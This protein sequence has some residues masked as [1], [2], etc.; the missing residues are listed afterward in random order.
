MVVMIEINMSCLDSITDSMHMNLS[1]LWE[2]EDDRGAWLTAVSMGSQRVRHDLAT[3]Q[4][5]LS[6]HMC[7]D[8]NHNDDIDFHLFFQQYLYIKLNPSFLH[9]PIQV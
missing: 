2:I 3:E 1:K 9:L 5:H 7:H 4:Q 6:Y 8:K